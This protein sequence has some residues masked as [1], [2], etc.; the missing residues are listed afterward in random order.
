M[1]AF[2]K[3]SCRPH[4][5]AI[6]QSPRFSVP[7]AMRELWP[8]T[9][10]TRQSFGRTVPTC[11]LRGED[12]S[13][14]DYPLDSVVH[15]RNRMTKPNRFWNFSSPRGPGGDSCLLIALLPIVS[16]KL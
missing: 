16:L 2:L 8:S 13:S 12:G 4:P 9:L 11:N 7:H 3:G 15:R 6:R 5:W 14:D 1:S 10:T